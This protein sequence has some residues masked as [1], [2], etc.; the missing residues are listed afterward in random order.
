MNEITAIEIAKTRYKLT[1]ELIERINEYIGARKWYKMVVQS[2]SRIYAKYSYLLL[3]GSNDAVFENKKKQGVEALKKCDEATAELV[4]GIL[5]RVP[6]FNNADMDDEEYKDAYNRMYYLLK[7]QYGCSFEPSGIL[8]DKDGS[9]A[10]EAYSVFM[11][12]LG[13]ML[14]K[15]FGKKSD[16]IVY[17]FC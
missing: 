14:L 1:D 15:P 13:D 5:E 7:M 11:K 10:P 6:K 12:E 3:S 2:H 17:S 16:D 9:V 8:Y 4:T